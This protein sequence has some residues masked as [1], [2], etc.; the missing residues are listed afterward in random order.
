MTVGLHVKAS[1]VRYGGGN[2]RLRARLQE[3]DGAS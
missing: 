2:H 1:T 3:T